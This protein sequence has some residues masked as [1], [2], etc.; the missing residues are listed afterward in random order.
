VQITRSLSFG[1]ALRARFA[2]TPSVPSSTTDPPD[3][4]L[5]S[6]SDS[7]SVLRIAVRGR[8]VIAKDR[9]QMMMIRCRKSG[10]TRKQF[11]LWEL[12]TMNL[13]GDE[14]YQRLLNI[15]DE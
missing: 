5:G 12:K 1:P 9:T 14:R 10:L 8:F 2:L 3:A 4:D 11:P 6:G 7:D 13:R 15:E